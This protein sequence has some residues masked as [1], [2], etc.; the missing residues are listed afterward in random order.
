LNFATPLIFLGLALAGMTN[1]QTHP[2]G[3]PLEGFRSYLIG[4]SVPDAREAAAWYEQK[5]GFKL[6]GASTADDGTIMVVVERDGIAVELL[7][8][9]DSFSIRRYRVDYSNASGR[10]QGI[11]KFAFAVSNLEAAVVEMK[12]QN[13][14]VIREITELKALDVKFFVIEDNN[15]NVIQFFQ[16]KQGNPQVKGAVNP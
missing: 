4:I 10:L 7:Q 8:F 2:Q 16:A 6:E 14:H 11:F 12:R 5:L 3:D 9:K 13:V 15:G 1:V